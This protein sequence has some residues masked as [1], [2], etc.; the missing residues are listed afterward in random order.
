MSTTIKLDGREVS[1]AWTNRAQF[2]LGS[3]PS[4]PPLK[5]HSVVTGLCSWI[6][7]MLP[8]DVASAYSEPADIADAID[9]SEASALLEA[10]NAAL[11]G[12]E[13][14]E[15]GSAKNDSSGKRRKSASKAG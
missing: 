1:L 9:L 7:A 2:R 4:V 14:G 13:T 5:G 12:A 8:K 3:L 15:E 10:V 11:E 6:W